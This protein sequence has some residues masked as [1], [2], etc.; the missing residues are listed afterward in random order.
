MKV[1]VIIANRND[2]VMLAVTLRSAIE[3]LTAVPG[4]GEV[5]IVD[6][7][8]N[9]IYEVMQAVVPSGY[10]RSRPPKVRL[11]RQDFPCLFTAREEAAKHAKG[12][13]ILCVDSHVIFGHNSIINAVNFM[14]RKKR[15]PVGFGSLPVNWLCQHE[16]TSRHDMKS[17]HGTWNKLYQEERLISWKG[18]PWI[19]RRDWFLS[20]LCGYF[21]LAQHRLSWGGGDMHLGLKSWVL[22]YENWAIPT[23]PIIHIGPLPV[24]ARSH[25]PPYRLYKRSGD[26]PMGIGWLVSL[27]ALHGERYVMSQEF[28]TFYQNRTRR[29]VSDDWEAAS[30]YARDEKEWIKGKIVRTVDELKTNP[31]W[32]V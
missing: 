5:V 24:V 28:N 4:G 6:N 9:D 1:S 14:N 3:E 18:M 7:S 22:G 25:A 16:R 12:E 32:G 30:T 11:F 2:T 23:R 26:T 29:S 31:P 27:I 8:D 20:K 15:Q 10:R 13:Y 21:S 17:I 19:C